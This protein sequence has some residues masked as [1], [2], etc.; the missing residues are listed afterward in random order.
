MTADRGC[1]MDYVESIMS[2]LNRN[3][4]AAKVS[5][6]DMKDGNRR[7]KMRDGSEIEVPEEQVDRV[8]KACDDATRIRL[9]LP[10][11]ISTDVSGEVSAWKVEGT[12]EVAAIAGILKKTVHVPDF[13]RLY[14][15]DLKELRHL[16]PDCI[17]VVFKP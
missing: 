7:Y 16:I 3:L 2:D 10:I 11:Y 4:A 15:P 8:W 9:K 12:A 5:L 6:S 13:L 14:Y 17:I 1:G